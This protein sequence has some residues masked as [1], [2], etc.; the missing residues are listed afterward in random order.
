[1][2]KYLVSFWA[3]LKCSALKVKIA[4]TAF[5]QL[6][7]KFGILCIL[8]SGHTDGVVAIV[9][10]SLYFSEALGRYDVIPVTNL[11]KQTNPLNRFSL[12]GFEFKVFKM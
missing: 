3:I 2:P 7:E 1:M 5:V 9:L 12:G 8:T 4:V 11:I 6:M 10:E